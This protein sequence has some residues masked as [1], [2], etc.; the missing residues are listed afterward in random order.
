MIGATPPLLDG[1]AIAITSLH[2]GEHGWSIDVEVNPD[3]AMHWHHFG[4]ADVRPR[5]LSWWAKDDRGHFYLGEV[6][7]WSGGG[8]EGGRGTVAFHAALDRKAKQLELMLDSP[9]AARRRRGAAEV[10]SWWTGIAPAD[11]SV[12]CG[13]QRHRVVW[14]D[15]ILSAPDHA[16]LDGER[17]LAALGG[18]SCACVA[19]FDAWHRHVADEQ[20]LVLGRR[21]ATDRI[22]PR[23]WGAIDDEYGMHT[24]AQAP[25]GMVLEPENELLALMR[26]PGALPDRLVATVAATAKP[27]PRSTPAL[28]GRVRAVLGRD[29]E[30]TI[31][32]P[33]MSADAMSLPYTWLTEV[34]A[35][36][37]AEVM[38]RLIVAAQTD[39]GRAF[40]LTAGD[41]S[42]IRLSALVLRS[43]WPAPLLNRLKPC[44]WGGVITV[45]GTSSA[46]NAAREVLPEP[47]RGFFPGVSR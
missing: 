22:E 20:A 12:D 42:T 41:G 38:G 24:A 7:S 8:S 40:T 35:R 15:G 43:C 33:A 11:V 46:S 19:I 34:W 6:G 31:G 29:V 21:G 10:V 37:L 2:S 32:E 18:E 45:T 16:D 4:P 27:G 28:Y 13:G 14:R 47:L 30:L 26:L 3:V 36:G 17:T 1:Y 44:G 39:D 5:R 9:Y 25:P 23:D